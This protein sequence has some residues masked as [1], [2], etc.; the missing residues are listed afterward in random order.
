[1]TNYCQFKSFSIKRA[2]RL[3]YFVVIFYC[4]FY[5]FVSNFSYYFT[6]LIKSGLNTN[7][8]NL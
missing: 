3:F 7:Y 6:S 2:L 8:N 1:M 4:F 5:N